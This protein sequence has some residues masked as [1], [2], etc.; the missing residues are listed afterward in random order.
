VFDF[1]TRFTQKLTLSYVEAT[2][3]KPCPV[4]MPGDRFR[5][6]VFHRTQIE[7]ETPDTSLEVLS[8]KTSTV[9]T[10]GYCRYNVIA[11]YLH[12]T[13]R[14]APIWRCGSATAPRLRRRSGRDHG[15]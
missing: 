8:L 11:T 6:H 15:P 13:S 1:A 10:E 5:A 14:A 4:G 7:G 3:L 9:F 12:A 2:V